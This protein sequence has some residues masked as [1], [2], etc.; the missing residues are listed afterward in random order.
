[1]LYSLKMG[2]VDKK[3]SPNFSEDEKILVLSFIKE[4][5]RIIESKSADFSIIKKKRDAW[6]EIS[7]KL[8]INGCERDA[9]SIKEL[10]AR[11]KGQAKSSIREYRA[12]KKK[13]G[14]GPRC[15]SPSEIDWAI[16]EICPDDF[17]KD[18]FDFDCDAMVSL[19]NNYYSQNQLHNNLF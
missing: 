17:E 18:T 15:K 13:T 19:K 16:Y 14:G 3:R 5:A 7:R 10:Y 12:Y 2:K 11:L 4:K 9:K 6:L 8:C 1:M